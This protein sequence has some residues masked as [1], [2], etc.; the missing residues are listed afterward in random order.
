MQTTHRYDPEQSEQNAD[1]I[2]RYHEVTAGDFDTAD[3][4]LADDVR[5]HGVFDGDETS[6]IDEFTDQMAAINEAFT[7]FHVEVHDV[8]AQADGGASRWTVTGTFEG[9]FDGIEPNGA[10]QTNP[11]LTMFRIEDDR[12]VE[13]WDREDTYGAMQQLGAL[14]ADA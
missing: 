14:P 4:I 9:E 10:E 5:V 1:L 3:Q 7:D 11:G 8:V 13:I 6:G 2:R 12:I